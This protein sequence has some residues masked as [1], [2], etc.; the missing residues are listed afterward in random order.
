MHH[1]SHGTPWVGNRQSLVGGQALKNGYQDELPDIWLTNG[2][3]WEIA[4]PNITYRVGFYGTVDQ[5]Q[6]SPAEEACPP[7]I[8]L[9][10]ICPSGWRVHK[11]VP[12]RVQGSSGNVNCSGGCLRL[13]A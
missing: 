3:P 1:R 12:S 13:T 5:F 6:W 11:W 4:R 2:N 10:I 7:P 9:Y 8:C